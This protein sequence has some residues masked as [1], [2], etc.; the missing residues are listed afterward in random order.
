MAST[1]KKLIIDSLKWGVI[2]L[3]DKSTYKDAKIFPGGSRNWDW[4]ETGTRHNPGIQISDIEELIEKGSEIIILSKGMD[5]V[6]QTKKEAID[7]LEGKNLQYYHLLT[8]EAVQ[9][10]NKLISEG[11]NVGGL[12]HSTC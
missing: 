10:Y 11:K 12:F 2:K 6:L 3:S 4:S 1:D 8:E 5:G 9:M 7:F